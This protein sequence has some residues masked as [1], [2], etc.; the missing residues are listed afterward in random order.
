M[1]ASVQRRHCSL[2][3]PLAKIKKKNC[4]QPLQ[5]GVSRDTRLKY[6]VICLRYVT[7]H[8]H[9]NLK[10]AY[11]PRQQPYFQESSLKKL[12]TQ[13]HKDMWIRMV[14]MELLGGNARICNL[15]THWGDGVGTFSDMQLEN[16]L[17]S[18]ISTWR[19]PR[20]R[21]RETWTCSAVQN[22]IPFF[23]LF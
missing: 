19:V 8:T 10:Y 21:R 3:T 23:W 5:W 1:H 18:H 17:N 15:N 20:T 14:T 6:S 2:L 12:K 22:V 4:Q 9:W 13:V 7:R 16:E 11:S